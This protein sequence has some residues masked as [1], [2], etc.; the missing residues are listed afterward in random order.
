MVG[1]IPL[2]MFLCPVRQVVYS[3]GHQHGPYHSS[4]YTIMPRMIDPFSCSTLYPELLYTSF[5]VCVVNAPFPFTI[6]DRPTTERRRWCGCYYITQRMTYGQRTRNPMDFVTKD[7]GAEYPNLESDCEEIM[8]RCFGCWL[9][10]V[11]FR[12]SSTATQCWSPYDAI[13]VPFINQEAQVV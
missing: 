5:A 2:P 11:K 7:Y 10:L 6:P 9:L 8:S 1:S 13:R 4:I 3:K 12:K